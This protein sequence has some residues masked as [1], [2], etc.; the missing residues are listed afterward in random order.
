MRKRHVPIVLLLISLI[1]FVLM[2]RGYIGSLVHPLP[3]EGPY[4]GTIIDALTGNPI[5]SAMVKADWWCY[6]SPDPHFGN[7]WIHTSVTSD[8][9]GHYEIKKPNRRGGWSH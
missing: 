9:N 5:A 6:D 3:F 1:A 2:S 7:Y 4:N 8:K